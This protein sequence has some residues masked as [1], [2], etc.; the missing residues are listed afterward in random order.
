[1]GDGSIVD[2]PVPAETPKDHSQNAP[3]VNAP[4]VNTPARHLPPHLP[5][6]AV[7]PL[8]RLFASIEAESRPNSSI[9]FYISWV[10]GTGAVHGFNSLIWSSIKGA[11]TQSSNYFLTNLV[12]WYKKLDDLILV[13]KIKGAQNT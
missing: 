10:V 2:L 7:N 1:M 5:P 9:P 12:A 11:T 6:I 3:S 8:G 4:S 13:H